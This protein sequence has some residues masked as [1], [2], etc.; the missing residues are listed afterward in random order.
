MLKCNRKTKVIFLRKLFIY[1]RNAPEILMQ[2]FIL[3]I[4][5]TEMKVQIGEELLVPL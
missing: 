2:R 1:F 4:I 5:T 3:E